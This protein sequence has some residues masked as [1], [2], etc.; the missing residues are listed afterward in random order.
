MLTST[1]RSGERRAGGL[2]L[3][4]VEDGAE[5]D[6]ALL[7]WVGRAEARHPEWWV[8]LAAAA[9]WVWMIAMPHP[10]AVRG[11]HDG[12]G[13][14]AAHH[15][16]TTPAALDFGALAV[17]VLAMMLPLTVASVRHVARSGRWERRHRSI[18][19]FLAGYLGVWMVI[20]AALASAWSM[21]SSR[22]GWMA[23]AVAVTALAVLWEIAPAA[24]RQMRRSRR[25][26]PNVE[27][28]WRADAACARLGAGAGV[29][30]GTSCWALMAACVAFG[31]G[32]PG[33]AV[34]FGVQLSARYPQRPVR[35]LAALAV[36]GVCA[37][38]IAARGQDGHHG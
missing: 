9:A 25:G 1:S 6:V 12:H 18:G 36:L 8:L 10:G 30:C 31:H 13:A 16:A 37:A 33:M 32:M 35:V 5:P 21:A 17:M 14:H 26:S 15:G 27:H 38:A 28:G 23:A 7:G 3:E 29:R 20:M 11:G 34:L 2:R 24:W 19:G 4:R 22:A